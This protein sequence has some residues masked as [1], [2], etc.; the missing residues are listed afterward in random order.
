MRNGLSIVIH[1][2]QMGVFG[3]LSGIHQVGRTVGKD[4]FLTQE[5]SQMGFEDMMHINL[6]SPLFTYVSAS[7]D[8]TGRQAATLSWIR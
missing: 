8:E 2:L 7:S 5:V 1:K 3:G 4:V 6:T